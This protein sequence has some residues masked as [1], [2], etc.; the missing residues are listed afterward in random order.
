MAKSSWLNMAMNIVGTPLKQ[1]IFSWFMQ[2]RDDLGEKY[3]MGQI[4]PPWVIRLV[5]ESTM[6]KQWNMGT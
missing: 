4:V 6:P 1:V 3:G 5:M 2:A